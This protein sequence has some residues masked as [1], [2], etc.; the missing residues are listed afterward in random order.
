MQKTELPPDLT[1]KRYNR[2]AFLY[3]LMEAPMERLR[4]ASWHKG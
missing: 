2:I 4:F 1:R 3:D